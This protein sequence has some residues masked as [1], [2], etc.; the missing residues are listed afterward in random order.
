MT[1]H[2]I[3][4]IYPTWLVSCWTSEHNLRNHGNKFSEA[5]GRESDTTENF[6]QGRLESST[7]ILTTARNAEV[8][9]LEP[10]P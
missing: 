1:T 6:F 9:T 10:H 7:Q 2:A 5:L 4:I 3:T 8:V